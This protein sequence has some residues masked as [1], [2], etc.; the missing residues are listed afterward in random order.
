MERSQSNR[1]GERLI[2]SPIEPWSAPWP[3]LVNKWSTA[4]LD[5]T[6]FEQLRQGVPMNVELF[7][8]LFESGAC[9]VAAKDL[10]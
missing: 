1:R 6:A 7:A 5:A 9:Q 8:Q 2:A 10:A 4:T 3:T